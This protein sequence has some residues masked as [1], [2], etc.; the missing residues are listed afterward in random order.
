MLAESPH[1]VSTLMGHFGIQEGAGPL[2]VNVT[3]N[4]DNCVITKGVTVSPSLDVHLYLCMVLYC[5]C[6]SHR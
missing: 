1:V 2:L 5:L 3:G 4:G 6:S